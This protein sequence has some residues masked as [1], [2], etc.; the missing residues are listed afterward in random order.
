MLCCFG[1]AGARIKCCAAMVEIGLCKCEPAL[2]G[3]IVSGK[4]LGQWVLCHSFLCGL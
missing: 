4:L 2:D 3:F 1:G